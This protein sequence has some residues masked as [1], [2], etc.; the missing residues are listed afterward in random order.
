MRGVNWIARLSSQGFQ[1]EF[2]LP[3]SSFFNP[4]L[5]YT[6]L[7]NQQVFSLFMAQFGRGFPVF[8]GFTIL[9]ES[10]ITIPSEII[11]LCIFRVQLYSCGKIIYGFFVFANLFIGISPVKISPRILR[12][13]FQ[14]HR[15]II[16]GFFILA[17]LFIGIRPVIVSPEI[18]RFYFYWDQPNLKDS[19]S[20]PSEG[21]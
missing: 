13:Y 17:K 1:E 14:N 5:P 19:A 16:Y 15:I 12:A 3:D 21:N 11:S 2:C 9:F 7:F 20:F 18:F 10:P 8:I 4:F 6:M